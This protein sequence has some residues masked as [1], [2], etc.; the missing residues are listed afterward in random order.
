MTDFIKTRGFRILET[1]EALSISS[2]LIFPQR[3]RYS[4]LWTLESRNRFL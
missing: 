2:S 4:V 1:S 3:S